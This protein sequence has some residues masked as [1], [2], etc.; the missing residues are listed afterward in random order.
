ME[1]ESKPRKDLDD[2]HRT[3]GLIKF[4]RPT[5]VCPA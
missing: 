5:F 1:S 2:G 3:V 4:H